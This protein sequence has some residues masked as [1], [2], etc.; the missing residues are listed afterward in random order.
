MF[1]GWVYSLVGVGAMLLVA[2]S[3]G[4]A[5]A[6]DMV[7]GVWSSSASSTGKVPVQATGS[8]T[9][10]GTIVGGAYPP[11]GCYPDR[12]NFIYRLGK[13][14][15]ALS[16]ANGSYSG[17]DDT[18][19]GCQVLG[20]GQATWT[21]TVDPAGGY[22]MRV[23]VQAIGQG[24]PTVDLPGNPTG[25][26]QCTT[27]V[28]RAAPTPA[29]TFAT[30]VSLPRGSQCRPAALTVALHDRSN[31]PLNTATVTVNGR[32]A[33][34]LKQLATRSSAGIS[35]AVRHLPKGRYTVKIV[36]TTL[37]GVRISG[38]RTYHDCKAKRAMAHIVAPAGGLFAFGYNYD[39]ELGS[40]TNNGTNNANPTPTL[41]LL[42]GEVGPVTQVAA[43]YDHSLAVTS[44]GQLYAFGQNRSGQLGSTTNNGTNNANP[45][46]TLVALPG[47]VGPVTQ[48]AAGY[49]HS[50]A[51]TSS[52]QLYA[53][54]YN[55]F[56]EL[57]STTN[58]GTDNAN[59]TATLV[60][61]PGEVGPV[62]Q[63]ATG[64][65]HS[66]AV[67]SSG[68]LYAFGD[69]LYGQLGSTTNNGTDNANPT[70]TLVALPGEVGP[71]TQ[72]AT[73]AQHSLAVTS[74]GQLYAFGDNPYGQLG[75]TTNNGTDNANPTATLV[76]LPGEVGPVTQ[77]AAGYDH[78]LA[79]TSS[80]QLYAFGYNYSGEL[81]STTNDGTGNANPT[82]TSVALPGE[83]GTVTEI[84]A[85]AFHS[86]AVTSSG[87][88]YAFG[89]NYSGELG[90]TTNSG[91]AN[92]NPT[93]TPVAFAPGTTIDA[94]AKGPIAQDT[95]AI[96]S[97]LAIT[98]G[99]LPAGQV[100]SPYE[101]P[102][103]AVGGAAPLSWSASGLPGGLSINAASGVISGTPTAP[104]SFPVA[105]TVTDSYGSQTTHAF[106]TVIA[107]APTP[108]APT[109]PAAQSTTARFGNQQITLTTPS[110]LA[111]TA[112]TQMLTVAF[113]STTIA[114]SRATKL[115]FSSAR[116]Y[117]DK[118]IKHV[119][120]TTKRFRHGKTKRITITTYTANA[121]ARHV[122]VTLELTLAG[123]RTGTHTLTV[124]AS[125][126]ETKRKHHHNTTVTITKTL[127]TH[128]NIC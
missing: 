122:P 28:R 10:R 17:L 80:G 57:G 53:F 83:S 64:A 88:L 91:T 94:V 72:V 1:K 23:C 21:V 128:F 25:T 9:F 89:Y 40:T 73:G 68:Q 35:I 12:D 30:L 126:K 124:K 70:P 102:M 117:L 37:T 109:P 34:V 71:V 75:S 78:S 8:G 84:A 118:G 62:T 120:R 60:A 110:L 115:R 2:L 26:T 36:A 86:L 90:S 79:V 32:V 14:P 43:G 50:L 15:W 97:G 125:F 106:T 5:L 52:G 93:P 13:V 27:L 103:T 67:T 114:H 29:P 58:N 74:S 4:A 99:S 54:G 105:V 61:L 46:A 119:R 19:N 51:V 98:S 24:A 65:Y 113:T 92:A 116:F 48:V 45:T 107:P 41:V 18:S 47:E 76:A 69:N 42:P 20:Q 38:Q 85:G 22:T 66:L 87:Q 121:T 127:T 108:P 123:L 101:A 82:P 81:G 96:V 3:P 11:A 112:S 39:G 59:P 44:S 55:Y 16:G 49:D 111:C 56:G 33:R 77:V 31:D 6:S 95:L 7:E 104:G 63:V 100:G